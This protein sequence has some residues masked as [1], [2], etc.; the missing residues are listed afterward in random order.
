MICPLCSNPHT[1]LY[2][3]WVQRGHDYFSCPNCD[4]IFLSPTHRMDF[5]AE[6]KVYDYHE[7][8][9]S[10]LAYRNF[11]NQL[12]VPL[13]EYIIPKEEFKTGLDFG[14]GSGPTL[15]LLLEDEGLKMDVYDPI[16]YP[17]QTL[18]SKSYDVVTCSE[19]F[20]HFK[21]PIGDFT[22]LYNA[23]RPGGVL[24]VMTE[25]FHE[26]RDFP[27]WHYIKYHAHI[28]FF[29]KKSLSWLAEKFSMEVDFFGDRI[30]IF[31]KSPLL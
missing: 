6:K 22:K 9:P 15:H 13:K 3:H 11:L 14:C 19:V 7:N 23:L 27:N 30:A 16:Y 12:V 24:G 31:K 18:L 17:D 10:D 20:E 25:F 29:S 2:Y 21:D 4:Y 1:S 5:A 28:G 26:E 8:D